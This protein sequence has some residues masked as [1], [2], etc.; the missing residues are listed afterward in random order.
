MASYRRRRNEQHRY[1]PEEWAAAKETFEHPA[2]A[3]VQ[4]MR[5]GPWQAA[6]DY[7]NELIRRSLEGV[8]SYADKADILTPWKQTMREQRDVLVASGTP[9]SSYRLGMYHRALNPANPELNSR[10]GIAR[11]R[12][13]GSA[14]TL[15]AASEYHGADLSGDAEDGFPGG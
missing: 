10:L 3:T 12:S 5:S 13:R 2:P 1:T 11:A 9:D 15:G 8:T 14:I 7:A 6:E 4:R